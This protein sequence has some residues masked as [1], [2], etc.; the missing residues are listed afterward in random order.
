MA[1]LEYENRGLI[2]PLLPPPPLHSW[3]HGCRGLQCPCPMLDPPLEPHARSAPGGRYRVR[4]TPLK[5][6][7]WV[8]SLVG[9]CKIDEVDEGGEILNEG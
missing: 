1:D 5:A 8:A 9:N 6:G 2:F 7:G 4:T 3:L